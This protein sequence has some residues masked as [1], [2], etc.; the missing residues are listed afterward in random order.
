MTLG[1]KYTTY[2]AENF[3]AA[4][5]RLHN[6]YSEKPWE[7]TD[8][9]EQSWAAGTLRGIIE[10]L[11]PSIGVS[12]AEERID[13]LRTSNLSYGEHLGWIW[14]TMF[15]NRQPSTS[16]HADIASAIVEGLESKLPPVEIVDSMVETFIATALP[17]QF[18]I[19]RNAVRAGLAQA[20]QT[21]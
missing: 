5:K 4:A 19:D 12:G 16:N 7:D 18:V 8:Y 10:D 11:G 6:N 2:P 1:A 9:A 20:L 14:K 13:S 17:P 3:T 21:R 15:G